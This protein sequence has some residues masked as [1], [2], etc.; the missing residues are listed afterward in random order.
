MTGRINLDN[1]FT[2]S[3]GF[4]MLRSLSSSKVSQFTELLA[5]ESR[6]SSRAVSKP[7]SVQLSGNWKFPLPASHLAKIVWTQ[8]SS[9]WTEKSEA[10]PSPENTVTRI[11][12]STKSF[13]LLALTLET[14]TAK[15]FENMK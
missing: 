5:M 10:V 8:A 13:E 12:T 3:D 7:S 6:F 14:L 9:V 15:H 11:R 1:S 2:G 4:S